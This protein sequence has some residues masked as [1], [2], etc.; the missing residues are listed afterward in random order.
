MPQS[1]NY[2]FTGKILQV[3]LTKNHLKDIS[4]PINDARKFI[5]GAGLATQILYPLL[6]RD[7]NPLGPEN[8]L[9]LLAGP[10][11]GTKVP[12]CGR[13]AICARSPL[14]NLWGECNVGGNFGARLRQA[15]YDGIL[16]TGRANEPTILSI[17]HG[18]SEV[19][20]G[21]HLWTRRVKET[22][23][24]LHQDFGDSQLASLTIGPAGEN[25]VKY[26]SIM[27]E[28]A[29]AAGRMGLGA[30]MGSKKLKAIVAAGDAPVPVANPDGL[31]K[32]AKTA[33]KT[34]MNDFQ[35]GLYR[36]MGTS[37]FMGASHEMGSMP[38]KY[39]SQGEFPTQDNISGSTMLERFTVGSSGC[40]RCPIRCGRV[41]EI[42]K[43]KFKLPRTSGPEYETLCALGSMILCDNLEAV[44]YASELCDDLGLDTISCGT[45]IGFAHYLMEQGKITAKDVGMQLNWGDCQAQHT[46]IKQ[47]A[48]RQGFGDLLAEGTRTLGERYNA[49][50]AAVHVKGLELACWG[51]R[52][53]FGM[54]AA[55]A[56]SPRG[57]SHLDADMYWVLS[58]QVI[59][60][61][62]ID[63]DDPQTDEGMG[64]LTALN[65]NWRM[66][67]NS[68]II[69]LFSTFTPTEIAQFYS[70]VTGVS[71]TP[72]DLMH[73]G[74]RII[75]LKR[76]MNLKLG[77]KPEDDT[78]PP[79]L[80]KPLK[81]GGTRGLV[82][83][84]KRQ[85][86]DY[87]KF[88]DWSLKTGRPSPKKLSELNLTDLES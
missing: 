61:L 85:L 47:I 75:N 8:P 21:K 2:G 66:V 27:S 44:I 48:A 9:L 58:G 13:L 46:L 32:L 20:S 76:L 62:G 33:T 81:T 72:Q 31:I 15:G 40:Y 82:P 70:F 4:T 74:E 45:T 53:L 39:W 83:D 78:I 24:I 77:F 3:D 34:V 10:L 67:T 37:A 87:Y 51:P 54:A 69:C 22:I 42:P 17:L 50:G 29:R 26:G 57:G 25:L 73:I 38:I 30:V 16:I 11:T 56:T 64:E 14:T 52:A 59:P 1:K 5:G 19:K 7:T 35:V 79:H 6:S 36:E 55:Y 49:Q 23:S 28:N 71:T 88:R 65:Q 60:E 18:R 12:S 84:V 43:G 86:N 41:V 68:L 63:A 80:L